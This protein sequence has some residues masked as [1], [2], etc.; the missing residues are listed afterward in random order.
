MTALPGDLENSTIQ[1]NTMHNLMSN[2]TY[3]ACLG[4]VVWK[5]V[6]GALS[7][8]TINLGVVGIQMHIQPKTQ[9]AVLVLLYI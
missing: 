1:Q 4:I 9:P 7:T 3:T 5:I 2:G 6:G 8:E